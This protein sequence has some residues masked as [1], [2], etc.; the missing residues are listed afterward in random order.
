MNDSLRRQDQ[1]DPFIKYNCIF[2][3]TSQMDNPVYLAQEMKEV[4]RVLLPIAD[5]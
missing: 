1:A 3:V 4:Q 5:P 2:P